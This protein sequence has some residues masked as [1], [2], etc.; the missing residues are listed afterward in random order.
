MRSTRIFTLALVLF[1]AAIIASEGLSES[2]VGI[3]QRFVAVEINSGA[4]KHET[5]GKAADILFSQEVRIQDASWIRLKFSPETKLG[6]RLQKDGAYLRIVSLADNAEQI[7]TS[8]SMAQWRFSSA[9]FN[10]NAVKVELMAFSGQDYSQVGIS[11]VWAG[12]SPVNQ[13]ISSICNRQDQRQLSYDNRNARYLGG[14]GCSGWLIHDAKK[15]FLTAGHCGTDSNGSGVLEFNVPLSTGTGA[16]VHPPPEDQF[17]V[18]AESVQ[19][20]N[21][22]VGFDWQYMGTFPNSNTGLT[23]FEHVGEI[24]YRLAVTTPSPAGQTLRISG[25]GVTEFDLSRTWNQVQKTHDGPFA[26]TRNGA[27]YHQVDT[28]GGNSGSAIED[29]ESGLA[30]AIHTHG[31]CGRGGSGSNGGTD[32]ANNDALQRVLRSPKGVCA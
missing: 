26:S 16:I 24:A 4:L 28:T 25:Y 7:L 31:G 22:G 1:A 10:G 5:N 30:I 6:G 9:Y 3:P 19:R 27:I 8:E 21:G 12:S 17:A 29:V 14:G 18:D 20:L 2:I 32:I 15:C 23:A 11:G 13:T